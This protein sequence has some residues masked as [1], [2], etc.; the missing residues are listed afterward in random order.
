VSTQK[1]SRF[2]YAVALSNALRRFQLTHPL[3]DVMCAVAKI[4]ATNGHATSSKVADALGCTSKNVHLH[5]FRNEGLFI[6]GWDAGQHRINLSPES[7][8]LLRDVQ[9]RVDRTKAPA[10]TTISN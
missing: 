7:V 10:E 2:D 6:K 3:Y 1:I 4:E 5:L 8:R 9:Q